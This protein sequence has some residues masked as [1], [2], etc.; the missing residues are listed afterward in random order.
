MVVMN[1]RLH[2][3]SFVTLFDQRICRF[4]ASKGGDDAWRELSTDIWLKA[5]PSE[6]ST[7]TVFIELK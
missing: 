7:L 5:T 2:S 1:I 4:E 3:C 6:T